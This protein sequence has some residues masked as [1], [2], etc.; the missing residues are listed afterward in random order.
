MILGSS[1][2]VT[3]FLSDIIAILFLFFPFCS[4]GFILADFQTLTV[5]FHHLLPSTKTASPLVW[6]CLYMEKN[7]LLRCHFTAKNIF[8]RCLHTKPLWFYGSQ[9]NNQQG[10][11]KKN[12]VRVSI[13]P[14]SRCFSRSYERKCKDG[15]IASIKAGHKHILKSPFRIGS[16]VHS[17]P[18]VVMSL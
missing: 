6:G 15:C 17:G 3:F 7:I 12:I 16:P 4:L 5:P 13:H 9:M 11:G 14:L 8:S 10:L 18:D 2:H 1:W